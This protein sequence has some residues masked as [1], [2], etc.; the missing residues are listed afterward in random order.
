MDRLGIRQFMVLGY[1][2][3]MPA[4]SYDNM[5]GWGPKPS[6]TSNHR[7]A[8][9]YSLDKTLLKAGK[10]LDLLVSMG[11]RSKRSQRRQ[12]LNAARRSGA[13]PV[14]PPERA[15]SKSALRAAPA[16][17]NAPTFRSPERTSSRGCLEGLEMIC[18]RQVESASGSRYDHKTG[19]IVLSPGAMQ[20]GSRH[21]TKEHAG[22]ST[23]T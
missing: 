13:E 21:M 6:V 7:A 5:K 4:L 2:A 9:I 11:M 12:L 23:D 19:H 8:A 18:H 14:P 16:A 10:I 1:R 22:A 17:L 3:E 20:E 15:A